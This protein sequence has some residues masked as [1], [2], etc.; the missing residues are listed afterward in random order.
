MDEEERRRQ[1]HIRRR[2]HF[3]NE[4]MKKRRKE[5]LRDTG[6]KT[7]CGTN[8]DYANALVAYGVRVFFS[9]NLISD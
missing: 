9:L 4:R 7:E 8:Y 5:I 3:K 6:I 1:S 2:F